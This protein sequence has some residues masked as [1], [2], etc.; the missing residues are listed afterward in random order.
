MIGSNDK[1]F[2][3][4]DF[5]FVNQPYNINQYGLFE[6]SEKFFERGF[7][8]TCIPDHATNMSKKYEVSKESGVM[9][10][11]YVVLGSRNKN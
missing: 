7:N 6:M 8:L 4:S 9:R 5:R 2:I 1:R 10:Q 3:Q 11:M